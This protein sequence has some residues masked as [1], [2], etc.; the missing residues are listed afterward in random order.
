MPII[1]IVGVGAVF[2]ALMALVVVVGAQPLANI[3]SEPLSHLPLVGH[4]V[5]SWVDA[6]IVNAAGAIQI[7]AAS[8]FSAATLFVWSIVSTVWV[9]GESITNAIV[10]VAGDVVQNAQT[11][12]AAIQSVANGLNAAIPDI[13]KYTR[14]WVQGL[15]KIVRADVKTLNKAITT[16]EADAKGWAK[17]NIKG[18]GDQLRKEIANDVG[19]LNTDVAAIRK[20]AINDLVNARTYTRTEVKGL[21]DIVT[22]EI[23]NHVTDA[24]TEI[25]RAAKDE[26]TGPW[27][28]LLGH[29]GIIEQ[30]LP[31]RVSQILNLPHVL[32]EDI[33]VSI[34]GILAMVVPVLAAVAAETAECGVPL[35][36]G[37]HNLANDF[38]ALEREGILIL[39]Y[40]WLIWAAR[41]P[42][43][44][45]MDIE[46]V[47]GGPVEA[48]SNALLSV[49]GIF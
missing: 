33:P 44:G 24:I 9:I 48:V 23:V 20:T 6:I 15:G 26:V 18:L 30:A 36:N 40:G 19:A 29:M 38:A 37:L 16:A 47:L 32:T 25:D 43:E 49:V 35:C 10:K 41:H 17:T 2:I 34:P 46:D 14:S 8:V 1:A 12:A 7:W 27:H 39:L 28:E 42:V 31:A 22:T 4:K 5:A 13:R 11:A 45:A 3:I 21:H